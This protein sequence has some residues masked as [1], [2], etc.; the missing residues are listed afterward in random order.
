MKSSIV[1]IYIWSC[2]EKS[3]KEKSCYAEISVSRDPNTYFDAEMRA[4]STQLLLLLFLILP[5]LLFL[6][7]LLLDHHPPLSLLCELLSWSWCRQREGRGPPPSLASGILDSNSDLELG[8]KLSAPLAASCNTNS[9]SS[10]IQTTGKES[11]AVKL[12][13]DWK[14]IW[15]FW[16][17]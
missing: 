7:L 6:L 17:W 12:Q 1:I 16:I 11:K 5:L 13:T 4:L 14:R 9:Y 2:R 10:Y 3:C 8:G 15:Y